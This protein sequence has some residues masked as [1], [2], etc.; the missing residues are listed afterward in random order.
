MENQ[1]TMLHFAPFVKERAKTKQTYFDKKN[2]KDTVYCLVNT[3]KQY[4]LIRNLSEPWKSVPY[5]RYL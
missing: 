3:L 2:I 5:S 4:P 1:Q